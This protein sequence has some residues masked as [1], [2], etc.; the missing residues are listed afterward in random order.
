MALENGASGQDVINEINKKLDVENNT[1]K[2]NHICDSNGNVMFSKQPNGGVAGEIEG[3]SV[4]VGFIT[5]GAYTGS[6]DTSGET[7]TKISLGFTPKWVLIFP[8]CFTTDV[9]DNTGYKVL[10]GMALITTDYDQRAWYSSYEGGQTA[11]IT[12]GGFEVSLFLN[13]KVAHKYVAGA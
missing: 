6:G 7:K 5:A 8:Q 1:I 3:A 11:R 12:E 4:P 13:S 10:G 9:Y 2:I